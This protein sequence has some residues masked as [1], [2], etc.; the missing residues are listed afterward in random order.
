MLM[1]GRRTSLLR[2]GRNSVFEDQNVGSPNVQQYRKLVETL[3]PARKGRAMQQVN[4]DRNTFAA[5]R[6]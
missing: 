6:V 5:S 2:N 1:V 3:D 4:N